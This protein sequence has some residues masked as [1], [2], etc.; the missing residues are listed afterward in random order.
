MRSLFRRSL[1][2]FQVELL[3]NGAFF[4]FASFYLGTE[5]LKI[6]RRV[7]HQRQVVKR[8]PRL[9]IEEKITFTEAEF[10]QNMD[11]VKRQ[12]TQEFYGSGMSSDDSGFF[13]HVY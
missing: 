4:N 2:K 8:F 13:E 6:K 7:R 12:V 3:R 9:S 5:K 10:T 1:D 11:W